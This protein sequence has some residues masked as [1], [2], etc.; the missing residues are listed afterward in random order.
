MG[1]CVIG[2]GE[3]AFKVPPKPQDA[4]KVVEMLS[5]AKCFYKIEHENDFIGFQMEG[6]NGI[7]YSELDKIKT[8]M[9]KMGMKFEISVTEF[10]EMS[11]GGYYFDS[12]LIG[13]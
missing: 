7:D 4:I 10:A 1:Y 12:D 13:G 8:E 9:L 3:I 5:K 11:N 2:F 6:H